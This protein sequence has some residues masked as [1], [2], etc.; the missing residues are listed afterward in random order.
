MGSLFC[1][2]AASVEMV[3]VNGLDGRSAEE[4]GINVVRVRMV[5]MELCILED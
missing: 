3:L 5:E 2:R 1:E 4:I